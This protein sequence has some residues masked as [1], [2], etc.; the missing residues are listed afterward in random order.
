[1]S[2]I[3]NWKLVNQLSNATK[4]LIA[5]SA[6]FFVLS[7][8]LE[9]TDIRSKYPWEKIE[10]ISSSD[11]TDSIM[12]CK[13]DNWKVFLREWDKILTAEFDSIAQIG[14]FDGKIYFIWINKYGNPLLINEKGNIISYI[15]GEIQ[16]YNVHNWN[17]LINTVIDGKQYLLYID[18]HEAWFNAD[19]LIKLEDI[20]KYWKKDSLQILIGALFNAIDNWWEYFTDINWNYVIAYHNESNWSFLRIF[21]DGK[22]IWWDYYYDSSPIW[23]YENYGKWFFVTITNQDHKD[24]LII[25]KTW[26]WINIIEVDEIGYLNNNSDIIP[27]W[28][29]WKQF[30][31]FTDFNVYK[32]KQKI[33]DFWFVENKN[34]ESFY[35]IWEK[36]I[37][38]D[39]KYDK[40]VFS[41]TLIDW[42]NYFIWSK[43][44]N[45]KYS[46]TFILNW[47][48][49]WSLEHIEEV[50]TTKDGAYYLIWREFI[51]ESK[52]IRYVVWLNWEKYPLECCKEIE[53]WKPWIKVEDQTSY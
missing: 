2:E 14:D 5:S 20:I 7:W 17:I 19:D 44:A 10:T 43:Y 48:I 6:I 46:E 11:R 16:R 36:I 52:G 29:D 1:M 12:L 27:F 24:G 37:K 21:I 39:W 53:G 18:K 33:G 23:R 15:P 50:W 45:G 42:G 41:W 28:K 25:C 4:A 9:K 38:Y 47:E 22:K 30:V 31:L 34:W 51:P 26:N 13:G 35:I 8:C 40:I 49:L 3:L 32:K